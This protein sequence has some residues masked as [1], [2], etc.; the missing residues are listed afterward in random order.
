M[1]G[2][3][4]LKGID[5]GWTGYDMYQSG[6]TLSS[7]S[8]S[9]SEKM[10][11]G[12]NIALAAVFEAGEPDDLLP[13]GV[14]LDDVGRKLVMKGAK[15]AFEEGGPKAL[16]KFLKDNLG[17]HADDAIKKLDELLGYDD[18][19]FIDN[20]GQMDH[21][22]RDKHLLKDTIENRNLLLDTVSSKFFQYTDEY[23][24]DVFARMLDDG[25]EVWVEVY[26]GTLRN[27]GI[28]LKPRYHP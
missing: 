28:N 19:K 23:G 22:F 20:P 10:F 14:P 15:E 2:A 21:I 26:N 4:V 13:V 9:Q 5:Y 3:I 27:G 24:N 8:A 7:S 18:V 1:V 6:R 16:Q 25:T 11:A 12:L 17:D